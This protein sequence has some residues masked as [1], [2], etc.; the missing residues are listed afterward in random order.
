MTDAAIGMKVRSNSGRRISFNEEAVA[1]QAAQAVEAHAASEA[2]KPPSKAQ[3]AFD[4]APKNGEGE[5]AI[6]DLC[7]I[8]EGLEDIHGGG[9]RFLVTMRDSVLA[10]KEAV[11]INDFE[12]VVGE[13]EEWVGLT[14]EQQETAI[15]NCTEDDTL[16]ESIIAKLTTFFQKLDVDNDK[17]ITKEEA[18]SHWGKNF[19]KINASAMFNEVDVDG[20]GKVTIDEWFAFWQNVLRHGYTSEEVEEELDE[21]VQGGSWVDF[22]DGRATHDVND[23]RNT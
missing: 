1:A 10:G 6:A 3:L 23:G 7:P 22:N 14:P 11:S 17:S 4:S 13:L 5:V 16:P 19:A 8:L 18:T 15:A 21:L 12:I 20:D 2:G 9:A